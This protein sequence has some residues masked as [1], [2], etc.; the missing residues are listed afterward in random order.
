MEATVHKDRDFK[1]LAV[2]PERHPT[3]SEPEGAWICAFVPS[4]ETPR[5]NMSEGNRELVRPGLVDKLARVGK[6]LREGG[7][8]AGWFDL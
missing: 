4:E 7:A 5:Q 2:S 1:L 6:G 3:L 8:S